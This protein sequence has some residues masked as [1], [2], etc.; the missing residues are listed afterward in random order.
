MKH[1]QLLE[2]LTLTL[3]SVGASGYCADETDNPWP[4]EIQTKKGTVVMY[5]P[6]SD[7]L[8]GNIV[9]GRA[10]L[11]IELK[12]S[13][14]PVF[15]VVWFD[16]R[17]DTDREE[18]IATLVDITVT[19]THFPDQD[20]ALADQLKTLLETEIPKWG[21]TISLDRLLASLEFREQQIRTANQI[22]T[23]APVIL[24]ESGPAVLITIDGEPRLKQE[25]GSKLM[26]VINTPFTI[27]LDG[28][29]YY[30]NAD[31]TTWYSASDLKGSWAVAAAV[32]RE[33]A[34]LAP[35]AEEEDGDEEG[36]DEE[37]GPPPKIIVAT[38][39]T[40]LISSTDSPEYTPISGTELLYMSNTDSDVFLHLSNQQ[41]Y[42]LLAGRWYSANSM[43]GPWVYVV[44]EELPDDFAAIPEDSQMGTV[45]Y[46]VPGTDLANEAVLDAQIPQTATIE[47]DK[48]SLDVE[49]DG[50]PEF[51][52]IEETSMSYAKNSP[53]PVI[54]TGTSYYAVDDAVWFVSSN[55]TGP[56]VV[57]TSVP[58]VIYTI[59]PTSSMYY[60]TYVKIYDYTPEV[61]YVG[62]SPGYTGT[63]VY[64]TTVVYGT[65]YYYP[66]WYGSYYYPRPSTW[67]FHVRY[68]P[69]T[70]WNFGLSYSNG[71]FTFYIGRG[72]WYRGGFWG[73][74]RYRGYR[75]GY[76]HGYRR[77]ARA[78]YRAGYRAGQRNSGKQNMYNNQRN[79]ARSTQQSQVRNRASAAPSTGRANNVYSDRDGNVHRRNDQGG[80]EQKTKSGWEGSNQRNQAQTS[81]RPTS[82]PSTQPSK[83]TTTRQPTQ[84]SYGSSNRTTS[85]Q[86]NKSHN[87]RQHGSQRTNNYNRSRGSSRGG[88]R[89]R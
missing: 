59:P 27:L 84:S 41:H 43:S 66:Y 49:Y 82:Q 78:G 83:P 37:P 18:R 79:K 24:F 52:T 77:G 7:S 34:A 14:A 53:T 68:N 28:K 85:Q 80:W 8:E 5:Q 71:P 50:K 76:R 1:R 26:R 42:V 67:G 54:R 13:E 51:E 74:A 47:R 65:G 86:L 23:D 20:E 10:A 12:D 15:G 56:W 11:A 22:S 33:V 32:P 9:A 63:Y 88:A 35:P 62:Y 72:S 2:V 87:N 73:P 57:A 60:V 89:R 21:V 3:L 38:E 61:V 55:A 69:Y 39:P 31:A 45:L 29:T 46:A 4:R 17:L 75:H 36:A 19:R 16:A 6:Q 58:D 81:Q 30:L 44:G 25:E 40:E 64:N 48:A 70:G